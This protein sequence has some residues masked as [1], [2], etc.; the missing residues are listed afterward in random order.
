MT[1]VS[2]RIFRPSSKGK[3]KANSDSYNVFARLGLN[4]RSHVALVDNIRKGLSVDVIDKLVIE[5]GI[6]QQTLLQVIA[7]PSATLTRRRA[8]K[9]LAPL[10]SDRVYRVAKCYRTAVEMFEGNAES[11]RR[12]FIE[13]AK[14][15]GGESPLDFLDTE[16]GA[17]EVQKLIGRLE[18]GVII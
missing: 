12:W 4:T 18:Q 11:A 15:L 10:E 5:L 1:G 9:R 16:V 14:A 2:A 8:S 6:A 7:L 17:D 3:G 13:P